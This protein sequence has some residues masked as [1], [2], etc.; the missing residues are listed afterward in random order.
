MSYLFK[1]LLSLTTVTSIF[2]ICGF[3]SFLKA[4][5]LFIFF[6]LFFVLDLPMKIHLDGMLDAPMDL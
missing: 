5:I 3:V 2:L 6:L 1:S 4:H